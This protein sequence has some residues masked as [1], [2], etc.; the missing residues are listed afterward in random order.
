LQSG[1]GVDIVK[2]TVVLVQA[3]GFVALIALVGTRIMQ[4]NSSLLDAPISPSSPLTLSLA[5]CLG[6]AASA[7]YLGLAA[8]IGA[9][10]AG[11]VVAESRQRHAL[12]KQIQP[13]MAFLVPFFFVVTGAQVNLQELASLPVLGTLLLVT[14]LA[15]AS[16]L[17]GCGLG[18]LSLG[19]KSALIVGVGMVPR[20]EVGIIVASLG[21]TANVFSD[22]IYAIIIA[23]SLLTSVIA[24]PLLKKWLAEMPP[25]EQTPPDES[26]LS[27]LYSVQETG[28][29]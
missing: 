12:E 5:L 26:D 28:H 15:V 21:K 11:M 6:L 7:A 2:L 19:R 10:L 16:K 22:T 1:G 18:A 14:L 23:M 27:H 4:K 13:I 17:I 29:S 9:F 25:T 8:I 24:P 20:G 3:V